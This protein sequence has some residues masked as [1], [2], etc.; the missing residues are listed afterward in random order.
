MLEAERR[1]GGQMLGRGEARVGTALS[2]GPREERAGSLFR[3]AERLHA[4]F[5]KASLAQK[6]CK[7]L[8]LVSF[9]LMRGKP[10]N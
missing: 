10:S 2:S 8:Y 9:V 5:R 1:E 3:Q 4:M 6:L 7:N